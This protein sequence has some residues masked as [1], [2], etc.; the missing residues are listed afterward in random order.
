MSTLESAI[1][2]SAVMLVLAGL[3]IMP[4]KLCADT[5]D[6]GRYAINDILRDRDDVMSSESLNTFLTG[7]SEN[8]RIIYETI[9]GEVT[10]EEA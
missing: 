5:I 1:V 3:I 9:R 10:D 8:Y 7:I 6:D 2:M 4:A